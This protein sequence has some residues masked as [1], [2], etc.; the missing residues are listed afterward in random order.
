MSTAGTKGV[1]RAQRE[2]QILDIATDEFGGS[3]YTGTSLAAVAA[4][5]GI[6][7][8]LIVSYFGSKDGLYAACADRAGTNLCDRIETALE[9]QGP[10]AVR[11]EETLRA[12]FDALQRRP[13]DWNIIFDRTL[14]AD[15]PAATTARRIRTRLA[16]QAARGVA[17]VGAMEHVT[18][19]DDLS[20]LTEVW[21]NIVGAIVNWWLRHPDQTAEQMITRSSRII[22]LM[23]NRPTRGHDS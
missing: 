16:D 15:G 7:K 6:S 14:P 18:D 21:M 13:H 8:P 12:F 2:Q 9:A 4:R 20:V 11:A 23:T 17:A 10:T 3:G 5:A 19:P 1:P 22:N